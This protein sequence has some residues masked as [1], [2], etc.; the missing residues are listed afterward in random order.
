[1]GPQI[2]TKSSQRRGGVRGTFREANITLNLKTEGRFWYQFWDQFF[3]QIAKIPFERASKNQC[4]K[5]M[6][7]EAKRGPK[8]RSKLIRKSKIFLNGY[9]WIVAILK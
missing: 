2:D 4:K 9:R 1:M 7:F 3:K 8:M 5:I 6:K